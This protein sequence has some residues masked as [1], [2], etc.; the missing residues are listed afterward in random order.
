MCF[1]TQYS[2]TQANTHAHLEYQEGGPG[3]G[4]QDQEQK[5]GVEC[6]ASDLTS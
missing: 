1:Y 6:G 4:E 5:P 3:T 2:H